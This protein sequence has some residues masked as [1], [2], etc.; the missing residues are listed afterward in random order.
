MTDTDKFSY[1]AGEYG[2][3]VTVY[4]RKKGGNVY[5]RVNDPS[6]DGTIRRSLGYPV[7]EDED[8]PLNEEAAERAREYAEQQSRKL[9]RGKKA[10]TSDEG[11]TLARVLALYRRHKSPQKETENARKQDKR[12]AELWARFLNR[13][14]VRKPEQ[15][16]RVHWEEFIALRASGAIDSHG[17]VVEDEDD[18]RTVRTRS[19]E[20]DLQWINSVMRWA[21]RWPKESDAVLDSNPVGGDEFAIPSETNPRRP[22]ATQDRFE[23]LRE[24]SDDVT[25]VVEWGEEPE[26]KR[27][28]LSELLDIVNLTGRR[29]SAV[30]QLR[31]QDLRLKEGTHGAIRWPAD[32]D[33]EG[34]E[35]LQPMSRALRKVVDRARG[36]GFV[37]T[38]LFPSPGDR[39]EPVS[40]DRATAW[41]DRAEK[42]AELEPLPRGKWHAFRRKWA[43]ERK[44]LPDK[45]VAE[46]G[47]WRDLSSLRR[48][49]QQTD[50][51]TKLRVMEE[52]KELRE[53][54]SD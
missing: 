33:K 18:R 53:Q 50:A 39:S 41:L 30:C 24:V 19:V 9:R 36:R 3:R 35:T 14:G 21:C 28:Y 22:V 17:R 40:Y 47:G 7:R 8:K 25:M 2:S 48:A 51:E 4:E 43:T 37:E 29:I 10:L 32:T 45:D 42:T 38:Y 46:V 52:A 44:H 1:S 31:R 27:S 20:R 34:T 5:A 6:G 12:R 26:E 11:P 13:R 15:I 16:T 54:A 23:A 49:Y